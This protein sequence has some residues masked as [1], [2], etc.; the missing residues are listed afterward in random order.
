MAQGR[1]TA[2]V[3]VDVR[4]AGALL[5]DQHP[6][7]AGQ[8]VVLVD[9]G[10][11]N[12]TFRVGTRYA[13][14]IPRREVAV[15]LILKEQRWLSVVAPRLELAFPRVVAVGVPSAL[16]PWPW[17]VVEWVAGATSDAVP[18]REDQAEA[19][20][21]ALRRLHREA[22]A[23]APPNPVRGVP[24]GER[25]AIVEERLERLG[26]DD[27]LGAL[28]REALAAAV[29]QRA[30]WLHGDLH[31]RNVVVS[32]NGTLTGLIDW[33][34]MTAGDRATDLACAWTLFAT[35]E[36][37]EIFLSAYGA[38]EEERRRAAGWA[39]I[40]ATVFF[41]SR[42]VVHERIGRVL[43]DRLVSAA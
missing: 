33:G 5:E 32:A 20:A 12:F 23:E 27:R 19:L 31:A 41:G 36:A 26:L 4:L 37:R 10:W 8:G 35:Q 21:A 30:V 34:D 2:E 42:D 22:P 11:D 3:S 14:R 7:F 17:S 18:L 43:I 16:F 39:V 40:F 24:L 25:A 38:T 1:P 29:S 9:E 15:S 28:W 13:L 6:D